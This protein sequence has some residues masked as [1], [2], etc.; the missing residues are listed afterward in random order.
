[1]VKYTLDNSIKEKEKMN[2]ISCSN[3]KR[4]AR[5]SLSGRWGLAIGTFLIG[6]IVTSVPNIISSFIN[7]SLSLIESNTA[8]V[9]TC[10]ITLIVSIISA[11]LDVIIGYGACDF[12]LN[13]AENKNADVADVFSGF[14][15]T[16]KLL[17][18]WLIR[19]IGFNILLLPLYALIIVSVVYFIVHVF[20][21]FG[22]GLDSSVIAGAFAFIGIL[23]VLSIISII[24]IIVLDAF[25]SQTYYI[26]K[27]N[28]SESMTTCI[29]NSFKM[30]KGHI[31]N[32]IILNLSFIGWG[33]L[34]I[35][36]LG[37]GLLWLTPYRQITRAKFYLKVKEAY[38]ANN[39][40]INE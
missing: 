12:S 2:W 5:G 40:R 3:L 14:K 4:E 16:I 19:G 23:A 1:M 10:V 22:G 36:T 29:K 8:I 9:L 20:S 17:L 35:F 39:M 7:N 21:Y 28:D 11:L 6:G 27:E 26:F 25:M 34:C 32:Y 31:W 33:I 37:I 15:K 18:V 30:M 38:Y 13:I 24:A